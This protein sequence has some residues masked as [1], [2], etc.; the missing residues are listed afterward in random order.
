[1]YLGINEI[2][3]ENRYEAVIRNAEVYRKYIAHQPRKS[4]LRLACAWVCRKLAA[5][6]DDLAQNLTG[7]HRGHHHLPAASR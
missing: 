6:L 4:G 1:M 2:E 7:G 3:T 5:H